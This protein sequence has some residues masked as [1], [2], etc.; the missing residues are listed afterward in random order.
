MTPHLSDVYRRVRALLKAANP[1]LPSVT[2]MLA[3][4]D[5]AKAMAA[6]MDT[7]VSYAVAAHVVAVLQ[8]CRAEERGELTRGD[9]ELIST[10]PKGWRCVSTSSYSQ[11]SPFSPGMTGEADR[12][13]C[14]M[15]L[16]E[17]LALPAGV[18]GPPVPFPR[19]LSSAFAGARGTGA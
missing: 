8:A 2:P 9:L 11:S 10:A 14:L 7:A 13:P 18:R 19:L 3:A 6:A 15:A 12:I 1:D 5:E 4:A 16:R 17:A